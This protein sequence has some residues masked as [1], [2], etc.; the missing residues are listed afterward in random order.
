MKNLSLKILKCSLVI[1]KLKNN[2]K[3]DLLCFSS[4]S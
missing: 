1:Q 2:E 4:I 3:E